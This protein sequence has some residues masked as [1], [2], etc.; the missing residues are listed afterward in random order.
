MDGCRTEHP[1]TTPHTLTLAS[2]GSTSN[3]RAY[4]T[5]A[6]SCRPSRVACASHLRS[7]RSPSHQADIPFLTTPQCDPVK[8]PL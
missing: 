4:T 3:C 2:C 6:T 5:L 1:L 7:T 8:R